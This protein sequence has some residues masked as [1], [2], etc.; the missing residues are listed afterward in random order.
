MLHIKYRPRSLKRFYGNET[1]VSSL[2]A[3]LSQEDPP[4]T[5]LFSGPTGCGKTTLGRITAKMLDC[6]D[7]DYTEV[8]SADFRGIDTV[9]DIRRNMYYAPLI[10]SRRVWLIDECHKMTNDAQNALLKALEDPPAHVYFILCTTE[11]EK[12]LKTIVGRC[13]HYVVSPL[14][15][16]QLE[17]LLKRVCKAEK[18]KV[19]QEVIEQ[20]IEDSLGHPRN[21]LQTLGQV[22]NLDQDEMLEASQKAT[23]EVSQ[24]IELCRALFKKSSWKKVAAILKSMDKSDPESVRRHVLGYCASVLEK[25]DSS[26]AYLAMDA[27][28]EPTYNIGWPG[29]VLA[30]YRALNG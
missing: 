27:F 11:P 26:R 30:A 21:A 12:L 1:A 25:E 20:I 29:I 6:A 16:R 2:S 5:Y 17:K 15:D 18:K 13:S 28:E 10:G 19:P 3:V 24:S 23:E 4:H 8:D 7:D 9:R 14:T 22:I